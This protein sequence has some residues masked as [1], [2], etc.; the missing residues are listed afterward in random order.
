MIVKIELELD[1]TW[2]NGYGDVCDELI[3][4]DLLFTNEV[5]NQIFKDGVSLKS[6]KIERLKPKE[7]TENIDTE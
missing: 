6:F 7:T 1:D 3:K 2:D 5:I 4:E